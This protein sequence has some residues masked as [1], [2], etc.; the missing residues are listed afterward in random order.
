MIRVAKRFDRMTIQCSA[1]L[2]HE[3]IEQLR[4]QYAKELLKDD[5]VKKDIQ[6]DLDD[7]YKQKT[8][9]VAE[10]M[11][12][13]SLDKNPSE[14]TYYHDQLGIIFDQCLWNVR[15]YVSKNRWEELGL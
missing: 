3:Q 9:I 7:I 14:M 13:H 5:R 2:S 6:I 4:R 12:Q 10:I 15:V 1:E 11:R 8:D